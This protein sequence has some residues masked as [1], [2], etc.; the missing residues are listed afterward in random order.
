[1]IAAAG[2]RNS[3]HLWPTRLGGATNAESTAWRR[4]RKLA[5]WRTSGPRRRPDPRRPPHTTVPAGCVD[6]RFEDHV[7]RTGL[8]ADLEIRG[9]ER[10]AL[11]GPNSAG[12]STLLH[13]ITVENLPL[14]PYR[15]LPQR[16][17]LL[18]DDL[19]VVQNLALL[20][21]SADNTQHRARLA[22]PCTMRRS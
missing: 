14:V 4:L 6:L 10:I 1:M 5:P 7:L 2:Q 15:L 17:Y 13:A 12:K 21:L 22:P 16:L 8:H 9:S 20:A 18:R 11:I 3:R 19:S